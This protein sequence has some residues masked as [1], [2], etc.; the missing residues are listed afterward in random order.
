[1]LILDTDRQVYENTARLGNRDGEPAVRIAAG[2][3][4]FF[5]RDGG[6]VFAVGGDL[7]L[8]QGSG[9][10]QND[11][12]GI[13]SVDGGILIDARAA[14]GIE[15]ANYGRREGT[16]LLSDGQDRVLE[17]GTVAIQLNPFGEVDAGGRADIFAGAGDDTITLDFSGFSLPFDRVALKGDSAMRIEGG[18]GEDH[19]IIANLDGDLFGIS[20]DAFEQVTLQTAAGQEAVIDGFLSDF[21][22]DD[23]QTYPAIG[24]LII[25]GT[26]TPFIAGL[27]ANQVELVGSSARFFSV[28]IEAITITGGAKTL[29]VKDTSIVGSLIMTEGD[30]LLIW[31][32]SW[33]RNGILD[34]GAGTDTL[35]LINSGGGDSPD[36][37]VVGFE[38][39]IV[40]QG[41][42]DFE[43]Y[44]DSSLYLFNVEGARDVLIEGTAV[45][46]DV[47]QGSSTLFTLQGNATLNVDFASVIGSVGTAVDAGISIVTNEGR[48][49]GDVSLGAG[50][51]LYVAA[52]NGSVSGRVVGGDGDDA[53][54]GLIAADEPENGTDLS[55]TFEGGAGDDFIWG[56]LGAD[57]LTGGSGAD[58]FY[59]DD[60]DELSP[61]EV[62]T[63]FESGVDIIDLSALKVGRT[64]LGE[65]TITDSGSGSRIEIE[66]LLLG[67]P[68]IT[69]TLTSLTRV[70]LSDI[71]TSNARILAEDDELTAAIG[72]ETFLQVLNNDTAGPDFLP[73]FT[74]EIVEEPRFGTAS[75]RS[76]G[77]IIYVSG[78]GAPTAGGFGDDRLTYRIVDSNGDTSNI[79]SVSIDNV[80]PR[81]ARLGE[82]LTGTNGQDV[83]IGSILGDE[84]I[85]LSGKDILFGDRGDDVVRPGLGDDN[86]NLGEGADRVIGTLE[87]LGGDQIV[88]FDEEDS[89][90]V[91]G[92]VIRSIDVS[93]GETGFYTFRIGTR[94]AV[95]GIGNAPG[96]E[97]IFAG[98][99]TGDTTITGE[100]LLP[101]LNEGSSV[102]PGFINGVAAPLY[103]SGDTASAFTVTL[104][105]ASAGADFRNSLGVYEVRADG[106]IA[107]VRL[108]ADD[109]TTGGTFTVEDVDLGSTLGFFIIQD[110][111]GLTAG[112]TLGIAIENG[113]AILTE[114]GAAVA[115]ATIFLS[116]DDSL[117]ADGARHVLS[118]AA[119]DGSGS[120]QLAFEDMTR[121]G[122]G[123]D[124]DFQDVVFQVEALPPEPPVIG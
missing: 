107:D 80:V 60:F 29:S 8:V 42:A 108:L 24:R 74:V 6:E 104:Q 92:T 112:G 124:D 34:G 59:Y 103:L 106:T 113:T 78:E 71:V 95:I 46:L 122:N 10:V 68:F 90:L 111:A 44:L 87:E 62:I 94:E 100:F 1:M 50:D 22:P 51:D 23:S 25:E 81:M 96:S 70:K 40:R 4:A 28:D 75:V 58:I 5:N 27:S 61:L 47:F 93:G 109:V 65:I 73:P 91:E 52:G 11:R 72:F 17:A 32:R 116:H 14:T 49:N 82:T 118:G 56:G 98:Q 120:L 83:L 121:S 77:T 55:D 20:F 3:V 66:S 39:V 7:F 41:E 54:I 26:G 119:G 16:L 35:M 36:T 79:A 67:N 99:L 117:N 13:L 69:Y 84:I 86:V 114:D 31:D 33:I 45:Q 63:D 48:I 18:A 88:D 89:I 9:M 2:E 12:G 97:L 115:G 37:Q 30:D 19:L 53:L 102:S 21:S 123:S 85:G 57:R 38:H 43:E 64:T 101:S 105:P 76:D 15:F 110:G